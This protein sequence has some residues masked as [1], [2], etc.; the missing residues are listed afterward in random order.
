[1]LTGRNGSLYWHH[2][3]A[4]VRPKDRRGECKSPG[5]IFRLQNYSVFSEIDGQLF[6]EI[7][8]CVDT[9]H[10]QISCVTP[11]NVRYFGLE[12]LSFGKRLKSWLVSPL[13]A[14]RVVATEFAG[15]L[16]HR[17]C[18]GIQTECLGWKPRLKHVRSWHAHREDTIRWP[19][20]WKSPCMS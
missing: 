18:C 4:L 8:R 9:P 15:S 12:K 11:P 7:G 16:R 5:C 3:Q 2:P 10:V 1:M 14:G 6:R 13:D 17:P 20:V 19:Q